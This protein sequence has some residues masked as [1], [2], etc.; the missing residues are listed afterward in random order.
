MTASTRSK[1]ALALA[2][3]LL[4]AS[5]LS[6]PAAGSTSREVQNL[7]LTSDNPGELT[8]SWDQPNPAAETYRIRWARADLEFLSYRFADETHRANEYPAGSLTSLTL[9]GLSEGVSYKVQMRNRYGPGS[10]GPWSDTLT[11]TVASTPV[12][13]PTQTQTSEPPTSEPQTQTSEPPT[14]EPQTTEPQT[15]TTEPSTETAQTVAASVS[16]PVGGDLPASTDTTGQVAADDAAHGVIETIEGSW[17]VDWFAAQLTAG[18][19]YKIELIGG[20][21]EDTCTALALLLLGV[22]DADGDLV[23]GTGW[24]HTDRG[25]DY[26][27]ATFTAAA[28]GTYYIAASS[29]HIA[30]FGIG[31]YIVA[32]TAAGDG[33]DQRI[34]T[35]ADTG[36]RP[37]PAAE[38][39]TDDNNDDG[40]G[41]GEGQGASDGVQTK[42]GTRIGKGGGNKGDNR[43]GTRAPPDPPTNVT[44][45]GI[46]WDQVTLNWDAPV[47]HTVTQYAITRS[48]QGSGSFETLDTIAGDVTTFTDRTV[49]RGTTYTYSIRAR[50]NDGVSSATSLLGRLDV[51]VPA[52]GPV[53]VAN[54][55]APGITSVLASGARRYQA[56]TTGPN[57]A[58]YDLSNAN[59]TINGSSNS[60]AKARVDVLA[61]LHGQPGDV[62]FELTNDGNR[63]FDAKTNG[64]IRF[65]APR[66]A[67]LHGNSRYW[68]R[69]QSTGTDDLKLWTKPSG[70]LATTSQPGWSIDGDMRQHY[71][72]DD[73]PGGV[74]DVM[75]DV[76]PSGDP[77]FTKAAE[78]GRALI[79][80]V[81]GEARALPAG[82]EPAGSDFPTDASTAGVV[83]VGGTVYGTL[84]EADDRPLSDAAIAACA[85]SGACTRGDYRKGDWFRIDG[86]E[87]GRRYRVEVDFGGDFNTGGSIQLWDSSWGSRGDVSDS[88]HDG[89]AIMEF[90]CE[91]A[92]TMPAKHWVHVDADSGVVRH[93]G[94]PNA[95]S[96]YFGAYS[97][98]VTDITDD[99]VKLMVSNLAQRNTGSVTGC[100]NDEVTPSVLYTDASVFQG[101]SFPPGPPTQSQC[102][103]FSNS[104]GADIEWETRGSNSNAYAR[105]GTVLDLSGDTPQLGAVFTQAIDFTTGSNSGGYELDSIEV[106]IRMGRKI[107]DVRTLNYQIDGPRTDDPNFADELD[108][109]TVQGEGTGQYTATLTGSTAG[110]PRIFLT[111]GSS[112]PTNR[113]ELTTGHGGFVCEL[114]RLPSYEPQAMDFTSAIDPDDGLVTGIARVTMDWTD[115]LHAEGCPTL[116]ASTR[117]WVVF[118]SY[119]PDIWQTT[120]PVAFWKFGDAG[121]LPNEWYLVR[122]ANSTSH[123]S[124]SQTGW[125]IGD[126]A[127]I[128]T[129]A[130]VD[131]G[132]WAEHNTSPKRPLA[133]AIH[134]SAN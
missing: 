111:K 55:P 12:E 11:V 73:F 50:N 39:Q 62:L 9:S 78:A 107:R 106:D 29:E 58:G 90:E 118:S 48:V 127:W 63:D 89:T 38:T 128:R 134:A 68:I 43:I 97:V 125:S 47:G 122:K 76:G 19:S 49:E 87:C 45:T 117:Y 42:T 72:L 6:V 114:R 30:G 91:H 24:D 61:D 56:F 3:G 81:R 121:P 36:C 79:T 96:L 18:D 94:V 131:F 98:T 80:H 130:Q 103:A 74:G 31:S 37:E 100:W 41:D 124:S 85:T 1:A 4:L 95:S 120:R 60:A 101:L 126:A 52:E 26:F 116:A 102:E 28:T 71:T 110:R 84:T 32:L 34:D 33:A 8:I 17:D 7:S 22:Y 10:A 5:V 129:H 70:A 75:L 20:A 115:R 93:A 133:I 65:D 123:D 54:L 25:G 83:S 69:V 44:A 113:Q 109:I 119:D 104:S 35:I 40:D 86:L 66:G 51:A 112:F 92:W 132:N 105:V 82:S 23:D 77:V 99:P 108:R 13:P 64:E 16:E 53:L 21:D 14:T 46:R 27:G 57:P 59:V 2:A 88:N 15:Q 67:H